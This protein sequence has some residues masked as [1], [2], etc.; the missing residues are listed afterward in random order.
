MYPAKLCLSL[1]ADLDEG[2]Q[3]RTAIFHWWPCL[4]P[5]PV[6]LAEH[7]YY[8]Y[9]LAFDVRLVRFLA[10]LA[11]STSRAANVQTRFSLLPAVNS[12]LVEE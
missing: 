6:D 12:Q 3:A 9:C 11:V 2:L 10:F 8:C 5:C 4:C 7:C 1:F